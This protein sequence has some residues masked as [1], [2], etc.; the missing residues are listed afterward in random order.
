MCPY[1]LQTVHLHHT[2][3]GKCHH[4]SFLKF[5][6]LS[7]N[8]LG[9][10][11]CMSN[12]ITF[13]YTGFAIT[14]EEILFLIIAFTAFVII[15]TI[16]SERFKDIIQAIKFSPIA[17]WRKYVASISF[18]IIHFHWNTSPS[19]CFPKT[20]V[21][22]QTEFKIRTEMFKSLNIMKSKWIFHLLSNE[23]QTNIYYFICIQ[24]STRL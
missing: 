22:A 1:K 2:N 5:P 10:H 20:K 13:R 19:F 8:F 17:E 11:K 6:N 16:F 3:N 14:T 7:N 18:F 21:I 15:W 9:S 23:I 4:M 24:Q 12:Q